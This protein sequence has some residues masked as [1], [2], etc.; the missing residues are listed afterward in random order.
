[1]AFVFSSNYARA[2]YLNILVLMSSNVGTV[3]ASSSDLT[4]SF[5]HG[6]GANGNIMFGLQATNSVGAEMMKATP[7]VAITD[8]TNV[9]ISRSAS[10]NVSAN[11]ILTLSK[12]W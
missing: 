9:T 10:T 6:L 11:L 8:G 12:V 3:S 1:M 4:G 2:D 5:A 7:F